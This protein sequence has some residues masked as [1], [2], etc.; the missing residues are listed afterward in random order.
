MDKIQYTMAKIPIKLIINKQYNIKLS[1]DEELEY[2]IT[3]SPSLLFD[4]IENIRGKFSDHI[5]EVIL[6]EAKRNKNTTV[7]LE[8]I[9]NNGFTYNGIRY[10]RFGKSSSQGKDGIT[11]FVDER[12]YQELYLITQLDIE[13]DECVISKYEA[14][15]CLLFSSCTLIDEKLPYIIVVGEYTKVLPNQYIRYVVEKNKEFKDKETGEVKKYKAR[16]IEEGYHDIELSPFDGCGCH[17]HNLGESARTY[18]GLDY[19][20]VGLQIRLPFFKGYSIEFD[21][22]TY[23]KEVLHT[24]T[25]TDIFNQ[26]HNVDDIDCIWNISMF[27]GYSLF[28]NKYGDDGWNEYLNVIKKYNFK[29]GISKYSHHV[30]D[31]NLMSKMNFQYLQ[32]LDLWNDKY[33]K[34][35]EDKDF[36]NYDIQS[37]ENEGKIIKLAKYSTN[38]CEKIIKGDKFYTYKF[39]GIGDTDDYEA[40]GKYLEAA[41]INDVMLHDPAIKQYIF[42]KIKKTINDMKFGKIYTEGFYHTLVGDMIGY[43]E[44]VSGKEPIGCLKENE[45]YC[46]T[47]SNGKV[48][49]FRSPLVCPSEVNEVNIIENNI[50]K[51]WFSH[52]KDQDVVMTNMFDISLP[53]QGGADQDGDSVL[54]ATNPIL[55]NSRINKPIIID[56]NDKI[57]AKVKPYIKENI[58]EYEINSR[59]NRIGEIT[60][61]ATSI[62]NSYITEEQY[63]K[64]NEDNISLLRIFQGKEIDFQ[65]TGLRWQMNKGL[66]RYLKKLPYFL[67]YRYPKKMNTY[68]K[69]RR[70]NKN[71][72]SDDDKVEL[73]AYHSPSP[74]NELADYVDTWEKK[75]IIW[76]RNIVDT[77]CLI[78]ENSLELNDKKLIKEIKHLINEFAGKWKKAIQDKIDKDTEGD[79]NNLDVIIDTYKNKL[80]KLISNEEVLANYVIKVSYSNMSISKV[81]AWKGYGEYIIKNLKNNTPNCKRTIVVE[82]PYKTE[83]SYEYLGKY[84]EMWDGEKNV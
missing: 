25:I 54:I 67:L 41:L 51:K 80:H 33:I 5:T 22:K 81:L 21:F 29:L 56:I 35:Y 61:V 38:L 9:L 27:K 69:L 30:K 42:R 12:I 74:M 16:E 1:E 77:R 49:S 79:Y 26:T 15:R 60:N 76:D 68:Y 75:K 83:Y 64:Q 23:L 8:H 20:P 58:T 55:I 17:S 84:Y 39:L 53:Q 43:L 4:Q 10:V 59:D 78:L 11:A 50:T 57:S 18:L 19:T 66:R 13:I 73:N 71:I 40:E 46:D 34:R 65:K 82:T 28:K 72:E 47:V 14:Q 63:I 3:Q 52:F 32:C 2:L 70:K 36:K 37:P 31:I 45:F 62:L 44:Y 24:N 7:Q 6:V 48:L